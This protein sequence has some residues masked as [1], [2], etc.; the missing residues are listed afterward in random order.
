MGKFRYDINAL[1]AIA[2]VSVL[3][4]HLKVPFFAGG[5]IGV[6][7]FFV[8]SGYLMTRII[9]DGI[10]NKEFS[11]IK[12]WS[13]RIKRIVPALIFLVL[14]VTLAGFFFYL[15]DEY[16]VNE[17]NATSSL[18]FYSNSSYWKD[19]GYF[20]A[21]AANNIF[22]HTWSLS[23]EWQFYLIYPI[24]LWAICKLF[25]KRKYILLIIFA[26]TFLLCCLSVFWTYRS[27]TASFYLLPTRTW[28]M[29]FGG[30]ALFIE[31]AFTFKNKI[32]LISSYTVIL[33]SVLFLNDQVLWPGIY[34]LFPVTSTFL[35]IVLNINSYG[36]LKNNAV[37][38]LGKI[39][40]S[41]YLW[42][43]PLIV[44][45]QYMGFQLNAITVVALIIMS[46]IF[47]YLSYRFIESIK[48]K[49]SVSLILILV[50]LSFGTN[51]LGKN[52]TNNRFFKKETLAVANYF[53]DKNGEID[54]QF[55]RNCCFIANTNYTLQQFKQ[56]DCLK[57]DSTK[58]NI[59][60]LGDSHAACLSGSFREIFAANH[61]NLLQATS[62]YPA[63]PFLWENGSAEFSHQLF[64]Y[65]FYD[66]LIKNKKHIDGIILGGSW[67]SNANGSEVVSPLL[68]VCAY[69]K[70][71]GIPVVII[72]QANVYTLPLPSIMAKGLENNTD[73][74]GFFSDKK[75]A[76]LNNFLKE[77]LSPYYVD[78][79]YNKQIP[80]ISTSSE[81][82]M[83]DSNHFSKYGA[84]LAVKKIFTDPVF[85]II[86][87]K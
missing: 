35:V 72:G 1:R 68:K 20:D 52:N 36:I 84:D 9:F 55:S 61:I 74:T 77:K 42:H 18:L 38:L 40:Y 58:K 14:I 29:L 56:H 31:R 12:F 37:Q 85:K 63:F 33:L 46:L 4:F 62:S 11:V 75:A 6:D 78:V 49:K 64:H 25:K 86:L 79:Y 17:K 82:Y 54:K 19:S 23:V 26:S 70:Q 5:F 15:P 16:M 24:V 39:S 21:P 87:K 13:N 83:F 28:E 43:W 80:P 51:L 60:L 57:I 45:A 22:L 76:T 67:Y 3:L 59:L 30:L 10:E 47:A 65:I 34:T 44:F 53:N 27:A 69:L 41:L 8:I 50:V 7:V 32:V 81:P 71:L 66:F 48:F 2:V 73:V